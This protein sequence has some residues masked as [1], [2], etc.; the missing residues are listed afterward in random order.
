M[1]NKSKSSKS[2]ATRKTQKWALILFTLFIIL[3]CSIVLSI[4]IGY[5]SIPFSNIIKVF[6]TNTPGLN[7]LFSYPVSTVDTALIL[8]VR[9][10]RA[11][12]A[13]LAGAALAIAGA[14]YQGLFRNPMADP[15]TIGASSGAALGAT[16]AVIVGLS[17]TIIGINTMQIFAFIGCLLTVFFVYAISRVGS[18]V[19]VQTLLLSGIAVSILLGAIVNAYHSL[20]PEQFRRSA[21][22]LMGS[23]SYT[24]WADVWS[25]LPFIIIG[26][27]VIYMFSR[28]LNLLA[29]GESEATHLGVDLEKM[30]K[31][32]LIA[33]AFVTAAAVSI[34]GLIAFVGLIIPHVTR[35]I[36]SPDHRILIP[37]SAVM[38]AIFLVLCDILA[39]V[40][41]APTELP[42]GVVT[43]VCGGPFFL[44]LMRR[45]KKVDTS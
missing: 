33:S 1:L 27:I 23:F 42:V 36:F 34:S 44:Y 31:I 43:A 24:E 45:K 12:C 17:V 11:L 18:K 8:Q 10:P 5:V 14:A 15:Y 19:P 41:I 3:A 6:L 29:L 35:M 39:R 4:S 9:F 2:N 16:T 40:V 26:S 38:G 28:D 32:L 37:A 25:A 13:A 20:F 30:K 22:W 21:F 7:R